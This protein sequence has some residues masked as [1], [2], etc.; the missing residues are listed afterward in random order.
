LLVAV[1]LSALVLAVG[2]ACTD[3][4][5]LEDRIRSLEDTVTGD[6]DEQADVTAMLVALNASGSA[7]LHGIDEGAN[8]NNEVV[9]GASGPVNRALLAI[10]AVDWP[11]ELR[12]GAE[13]SMSALEALLEALGADNPTPET[14]G[15]P[16][17]SAHDVLHDFDSDVENHIRES[18]GL[19]VEDEEDH[20]E[21]EGTPSEGGETP[22]EGQTPADGTDE[23]AE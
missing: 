18:V 13:D 1:A 10:A 19:A 12:A 2:A 6:T 11:E 22:S 8:E 15:P 5:D 7:G 3:T 14:V 16:A 21:E 17:A 4:E 9:A 20:G 23:H